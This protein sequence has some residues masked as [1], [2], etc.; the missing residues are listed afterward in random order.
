VLGFDDLKERKLYVKL[1]ICI[2][3]AHRLQQT[4]IL[5]KPD[6]AFLTGIVCPK[7]ANV[8]VQAILARHTRIRLGVAPK[9]HPR[10]LSAMGAVAPCLR[11]RRTA[12]VHYRARRSQR[13]RQGDG[14][15]LRPAGLVRVR[16]HHWAGTPAK[17]RRAEGGRTALAWDTY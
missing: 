4:S 2:A 15:P 11:S 17:G 5:P 12:G 9:R 6:R 14:L 3:E 1:A 7:L 16:S 13:R 10:W 8:S